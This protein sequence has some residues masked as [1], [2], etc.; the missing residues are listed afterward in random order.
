MTV[1]IFLGALRDAGDRLIAFLVSKR[2]TNRRNEISNL[3]RLTGKERKGAIMDLGLSR[4]NAIVCGSSKGLGLACATALARAGVNVLLNGRTAGSLEH[5]RRQLS[6]ELGRNVE[7]VAADVTREEGR[8]A[9]LGAMPQPDIIITNAA[10][11]APGNFEDWSEAVWH[12]ALSTNMIAPIQF[13]RLVIPGMRQRRWGRIINITSSAVKAPLPLL[14]LSNGARSGLTGVVA[15]LAREVARDG[16]TINNLLP[17]FFDTNR[18]R[19]LT[20]A[21]ADLSGRSFEEVWTSK[22]S[23]NP[24]GRLGDPAE[25]GAACAFLAS[26]HAGYINGQNWLLDGGA[27]PGTF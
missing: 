22:A 8:A 1:A 19:S 21:E 17:G 10:G 25:F 2:E 18:L 5:A 4:K 15:G 14:G 27:Y 7:A 6:E 23:A 24:T 20:M 26:Q 9:L 12:D 13:M 3:P 16:V 11:P